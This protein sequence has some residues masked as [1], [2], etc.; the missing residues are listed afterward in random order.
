MGGGLM[1]VQV[2]QRKK[3]G[4]F[5]LLFTACAHSESAHVL[6]YEQGQVLGRS[7]LDAPAQVE[8]DDS[9]TAELDQTAN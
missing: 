1:Q 7:L 2:F 4:A 9:D 8:E 6:S 3:D 5:V